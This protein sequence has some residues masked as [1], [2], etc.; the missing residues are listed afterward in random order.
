MA[1]QFL[2]LLLSFTSIDPQESFP[3]S[4]FVLY[5]A[6]LYWLSR[7]LLRA[8]IIRESHLFFV[9][10]SIF[11]VLSILAVLQF[12]T[13]Q[14]IGV[15]PSYFGENLSQGVQE[16]SQ[17]G[18]FRVGG[19]F[20]H[21]NSFAQVYAIYGSIIV[22]FLLFYSRRSR[23]L[24]ALTTS[25]LTVGISA[26]SLSRGG[27]LSASVIQMVLYLFW[28]SQGG[29][30]KN[31]RI[32]AILFIGMGGVVV[33]LILISFVDSNL[34]PGMARL[35]NFDMEDNTNTSRLETYAAALQILK[36]PNILILGVG[37]GQFYETVALHGIHIEWK[38]YLLPEERLGS[39]HNWFLLNAT[40]HGL[41]VL[42]LYIY[43]IYKT[44]LR[45]WSL[46][47]KPK[48]QFAAAISMILIVMYLTGFQFD[49]TGNTVWLLTPIVILMAWIQNEYD[50]QNSS[51]RKYSAHAMKGSQTGK[52][53]FR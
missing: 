30:N 36:E 35:S 43:A 41:I 42:M 45:G 10:I 37:S 39:V 38:S 23:F 7:H 12:V 25:A 32:A 16:D 22:A 1:A 51:F 24:V 15:V 2:T 49:T 5:V 48:G 11:I 40:E 14:N 20:A 8:R 18:G 19:T 3:L 9:V 46:R 47:K 31:L 44:T 53:R 13:K 33:A 34:I 29:R 21:S 27:V 4:L 52:I 28:M 26:L 6:L 50:L 17:T